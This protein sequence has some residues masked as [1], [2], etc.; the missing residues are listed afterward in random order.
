MKNNLLNWLTKFKEDTTASLT[1]EFVLI[2]PVLVTWFI[3]SIVFFDAFNS[4]ATAQRT[5][6]TIADIISRQ[7]NTNNAF[8][9]TLLLVQNRMLPREDVGTVRVSSLQ[10]DGDG[11][12]SLSWTHSSD[13]LS[14]PL[15]LTDIPASALPDIA[16]NESIL[17]V[18]TTVPFEPISEWVGFTLTQWENRVAIKPRFVEPLQNSDFP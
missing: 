3:G 4:K 2:L 9:D 16:D 6:H 18:D 10:R 14:T 15:I 13:A 17:I 5:A 8:I 12:L 7:T 11:N 1:V